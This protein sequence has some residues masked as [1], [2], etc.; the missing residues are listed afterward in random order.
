[1]SVPF[2]DG[3]IDYNVYDVAHSICAEV[4]GKRDYAVILEA[5]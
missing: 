3:A 2:L 4:C 5:S 1:M